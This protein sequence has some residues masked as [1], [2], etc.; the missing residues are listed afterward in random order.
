ME[1]LAKIFKALSDETRLKVIKLLEKGEL[2]VCEIVEAL[3]MIQPKVSF[4][5]SVL[6][7]AGLVKMRRE[8][9][10]IIYSLDDADLFKRFLIFSVL[11]KIPD[12][13]ITNELRNL[14]RFKENEDP[15]LLFK[16]Q[17]DK[18]I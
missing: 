6:K 10:W 8:G 15:R 5:L 13:K 11:E 2:C 7:D 12:E 17:K 4:H 16:L 1:K 9:K 18:N 3:N 14:N